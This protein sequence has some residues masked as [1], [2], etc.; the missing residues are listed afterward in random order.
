MLKNSA[1]IVSD[2]KNVFT[3]S[4]WLHLG[5]AD[6]S[7]TQNRHELDFELA[8]LDWKRPEEFPSSQ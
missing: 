5:E 4:P 6:S 7:N 2:S 3:G 1:V 8:I